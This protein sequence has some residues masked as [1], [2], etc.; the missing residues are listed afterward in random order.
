MLAVIMTL[1]LTAT[2]CVSSED[3]PVEPTPPPIT[4][5]MFQQQLEAIS[6]ISDITVKELNNGTQVYYFNVEQLIDHNA[7]SKGTFKQRVAMTFKGADHVTVLYTEGYAMGSDGKKIR[8]TDL[9]DYY[10]ANTIEVE[11]RYFGE[12]LPEP[13]ED[14]NYTY[15]N[16]EQAVE[17]MHYVV[18]L[19]KNSKICTGKWIATGI[20]K[21]GVNAALYAYYSEKKGY[22]DIDV[23]V[24]FCS[25][26]LT[27]IESKKIGTYMITEAGKST[28]ILDKLNAIPQKLVQQPTR[29][30]FIKMIWEKEGKIIEQAKDIIIRAIFG[31][32]AEIDEADILPLLQKRQLATRF[33]QYYE[34]L[35]GKLAYIP[36]PILKDYIPDPETADLAT[37][38]RFIRETYQDIRQMITE[39]AGNRAGL[40]DEELVNRR[41]QD[42]Q[43]PYYIQ[44]YKEL[45]TYDFDY[46]LIEGNG[47]ITE[48]D[49]RDTYSR[50][51]N[52]VFFERY[53]KQYSN[54]MTK[55]FLD[56]F[57]PT[58][59]KKMVFV[60]CENDPWTGGAI[61]DSKNP[62][63]VKFVSPGGCHSDKILD[64][65]HFPKE[66]RDKIIK[67]INTFLGL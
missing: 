18:S 36:A 38:D 67:Q 57:L 62:N 22:D 54:K 20:S 19:I 61:P 53:A 12:S 49:I 43:F 48:K 13:L 41:K 14:V 16:A 26:I 58:S 27:E 10:N 42:P 40:T 59:K 46:S 37:L 51:N 52:L 55:D 3:N 11:H 21:S 44:A 23:Y 17:D 60:Y 56:N 39:K 5:E 6:G 9:Y 4:P 32:D 25:P 66:W 28:G 31:P 8:W 30:E 2:S 47:Y 65:D 64:E 63:V 33:H 1:G 34:N 24:P 29:D 7:P 35:F 15:L 45:G 50:R